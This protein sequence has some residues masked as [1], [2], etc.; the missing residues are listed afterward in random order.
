VV[1]VT[2]VKELYFRQLA[3]WN[4]K[5]Q[6]VAKRNA[7]NHGYHG[8]FPAH[9]PGGIT[10]QGRTWIRLG[11]GW[12]DEPTDTAYAFP[13]DQN[14][15]ELVD[16]MDE[17]VQELTCIKKEK[18]ETER[19]LSGL[20]RFGFNKELLKEALG[21]TLFDLFNQHLERYYTNDVDYDAMRAFVSRH[22]AIVGHMNARIML[23]LITLDALDIPTEDT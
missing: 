21:V 1:K 5:L 16:E 18:Y 14:D 22:E 11:L 10:Y 2:L 20:L 12:L 4:Y 9:K 15:S 7:M 13:L 23:N 6:E 8:D 17:I 3:F 19:F